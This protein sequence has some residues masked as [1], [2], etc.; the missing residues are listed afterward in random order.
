MLS[1]NKLKHA[2]ACSMAVVEFGPSLDVP[3]HWVK[4][5]RY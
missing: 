2:Y 1:G 5:W 4:V 3:E